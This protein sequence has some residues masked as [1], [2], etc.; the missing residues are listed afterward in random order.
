MND[1]I[2]ND[3]RVYILTTQMLEL[4]LVTG[5]SEQRSARRRRPKRLR[6]SLCSFSID[7]RSRPATWFSSFSVVFSTLKTGRLMTLLNIIQCL[8]KESIPIDVRCVESSLV[9]CV[10]FLSFR[11][12]VSVIR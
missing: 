4:L 11:V 9:Q 7:T 3:A 10:S 5:L 1:Y 6:S 12:S 2:L 8:E